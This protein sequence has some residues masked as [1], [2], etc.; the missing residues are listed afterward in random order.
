MRTT[1]PSFAGLSPRSDERIAFSMAVISDGSNGCATISVGS[2]TE[3]V[4][5]WL[6][7]IFEP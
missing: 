6:S 1:L 3:S 4:A 5:T 2:G 7:G